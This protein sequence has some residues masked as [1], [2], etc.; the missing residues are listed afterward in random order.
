VRRLSLAAPVLALFLAACGSMQL[1]EVLQS[2]TL[3]FGTSRVNAAAVS[4]AEWHAFVEEVITPRFPGFTAWEAEGHWKGDVERT[5]V[6]QIIH[7]HRIGE[8]RRVAEIIAEYKR[9]FQQESVLW[10]RGEALATFQ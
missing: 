2:D 4:E 3:F 10:V 9:R 6:V 8:E 1:V 5:H 7:G